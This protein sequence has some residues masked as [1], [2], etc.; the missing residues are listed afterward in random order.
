MYAFRDLCIPRNKHRD[1]SKINKTKGLGFVC[2]KCPSEIVCRG[3]V[4]VH[5]LFMG[6]HVSLCIL[7][8]EGEQPASSQGALVLAY[9]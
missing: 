9:V 2:N 3:S 5:A 4:Y 1:V 6:E 8:S 7:G